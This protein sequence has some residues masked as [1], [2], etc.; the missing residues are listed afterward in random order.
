[1]NQNPKK[2]EMII[3]TDVEEEGAVVA[4]YRSKYGVWTASFDK[5]Q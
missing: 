4:I 2:E 5:I 1:M 3:I